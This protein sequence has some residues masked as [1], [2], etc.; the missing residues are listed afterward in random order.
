MKAP[1]FAVQALAAGAVA[2]MVAA[3]GSSPTT[4][5][6]PPAPPSTPPTSSAPSTTGTAAVATIT[7]NWE[8]FFDAAKTP[9]ST[10]ISLLE[11]G[12]QFPKSAL[13]AKGLAAG[14]S[15][16]V[17]TVTSVTA[18]T[19][20]VKYNILLGGTPA[21]KDQTGTAVYQDGTWKVGISSFCALLTLEKSSGFLSSV[22][23]VCSSGT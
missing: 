4:T 3:C 23:S 19:A 21:L 16:K 20:A 2:A 5:T 22:P 10:R 12:S 18:S 6:K 8:T 1:R 15:A 9:V 14:A 11:N 13:E 17:L 7:K